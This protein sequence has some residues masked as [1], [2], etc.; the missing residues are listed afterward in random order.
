MSEFN[1]QQPTNKVKN[2]VKAANTIKN[3]GKAAWQ[4]ISFL[5]SPIGIGLIVCFLVFILISALIYEIYDMT[6]KEE[7]IPD[8]MEE[9]D[10]AML[11]SRLSEQSYYILIDDDPTIYQAGSDEW[12]AKGNIQDI[13]NRESQFALSYPM[14]E[15]LDKQLNGDYVNPEQFI[16]PVYNSCMVNDDRKAEE[17]EFCEL[18]QLTNDDGG[19]EADSTYYR[20]R[21]A[22]DQAIHDV[23]GE[24][25]L[26]PLNEAGDVYDVNPEASTKG[27]WN[28]GLASLIHYK[29]FNQ[30]SRINN[31][32][33]R[34]IDY[35]DEENRSVVTLDNFDIRTDQD[36]YINKFGYNVPDRIITY[37]TQ[38]AEN[39]VST[40]LS[41]AVPADETR[42]AID[43]ATTYV[44]TIENDVRQVW[45][46]QGDSGASSTVSNYYFEYPSNINEMPNASYAKR[47]AYSYSYG[48]ISRVDK[49]DDYT[50]FGM[51]SNATPVKEFTGSVYW[52]PQE[53]VEWTEQ[54]WKCWDTEGE[55]TEDGEVIPGTECGMVDVKKSEV[56]PAKYV[57]DDGTEIEGEEG[58]LVFTMIYNPPLN[59]YK[60]GE[61]QTYSVKYAQTNPDTTKIVGTQYLEDYIDNYQSFVAYDETNENIYGCYNIGLELDDNDEYRSD[62]LRNIS[63]DALRA[64]GPV[65]EVSDI[66]SCPNNTIVLKISGNNAMTRSDYTKLPEAHIQ[67][68]KAL[69]GYTENDDE[70]SSDREPVI[71]DLT[72]A[73]ASSNQQTDD[74]KTASSRYTSTRQTYGKIINQRGT[75]YGVDKDLLT[76]ICSMG[77]GGNMCNITQYVGETLNVYNFSTRQYDQVTIDPNSWG[78]ADLNVK[79][80]SAVLQQL[81]VE[82]DY[83]IPMVIE[84]YA[85]GVN[86]V[87]N[88]L[89]LYEQETGIPAD[90]AI[91]DQKDLT[92]TDYLMWYLNDNYGDSASDKLL[93]KK[94]FNTFLSSSSI[95]FQSAVDDGS[96]HSVKTVFLSEISRAQPNAD[97]D[98]LS[99]FSNVDS[100]Y[101]RN[102]NKIKDIWD[103]L[104]LGDK[105]FNV[106][107]YTDAVVT[108]HNSSMFPTDI[109]QNII[110]D[111]PQT[112]IL[113]DI[114]DMATS[115]KEKILPS[116]FVAGTGKDI[117]SLTDMSENY[118][119]SKYSSMFK[120]AGSKQWE[121]SV[122]AEQIFG[123]LPAVPVSNYVEALGFG[124]YYDDNGY[125]EF[126]EMTLLG[127]VRGS[128]V[129]AVA[130]GK[131]IDVERNPKNKYVGSYVQIQHSNPDGELKDEVT[132]EVKSA[133]DVITTYYYLGN[134]TVNIN[135]E[136]RA[137]DVIGYA[138]DMTGEDL[139]VDID[140]MDGMNSLIGLELRIDGELYDFMDIYLAGKAMQEQMYLAEQYSGDGSW[141]SSGSFISM[142]DL[143]NYDYSSLQAAGTWSLSACVD[144]SS[145][146]H[147]YRSAG[148]W[149]YPSGYYHPALD[150]ATVSGTPLYAMSDAQVLIAEGAC[151]NTPYGQGAGCDPS[152]GNRVVYAINHSDGNTYVI[153]YLHM[154]PGLMVSAGDIVPAGT[155]LGYSGNSGMSEGPH[156]HIEI[157][158]VGPIGIE[159]AA[160]LVAGRGEY[161]IGYEVP[162]SQRCDYN[163]DTPICREPP[164]KLFGV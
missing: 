44:G 13:D 98:T 29:S 73:S 102:K 125:E 134:I 76:A 70:N 21:N 32:Q 83:N 111:L 45:I 26:D 20:K 7:S 136:V 90:Q 112:A 77:E 65:S 116:V 75:Q 109:M 16:K 129:F 131:V 148:T 161:F 54:E 123:A 85:I 133:P 11:Y 117:E 22:S 9:V 94:I 71:L 64:N 105:D 18:I 6:E 147:G 56:I 97:T 138:G 107:D 163:G 110:Q 135:D 124:T 10:M 162:I 79:M 74:F 86:G 12:L 120:T 57:F 27:I 17:G 146:Y 47:R 35:W 143:G 152:R 119:K 137:G 151:A 46:Y 88:T 149:A 89:A 122:D 87:R 139:D 95:S 59:Y 130:D 106:A 144:T 156:V 36:T 66:A 72:T 62:E 24:S 121:S 31:Y 2:T 41:L 82:L 80:A 150:W 69:T 113:V 8:T 14:L 128:K 114:D 60:E 23:V 145:Q 19:L 99:A 51:L 53:I 154:S 5:I 55:T 50:P 155:L 157:I 67:W 52:K 158:N 39:A 84:A 61:L 1:D 103:A 142:D 141:W 43:K 3:V 68:I 33:I 115:D 63:V 78:N 140:T 25:E 126:S 48:T 164:D 159:G 42:Y 30:T 91:L 40:G 160:S 28:W 93:I 38:N 15:T 101:L 4:I 100:M 127:T 96:L 34:T 104:F 108:E 37:D 92:W 58:S 153:K 81:A 132:G 118:W 49:T